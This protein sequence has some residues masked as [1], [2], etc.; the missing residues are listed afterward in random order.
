MKDKMNILFIWPDEP[1]LPVSLFKHFVYLGETAGLM[2]QKGHYVEVLDLSVQKI[3]KPDFINKLKKQDVICIPIEIY[4]AKS[5]TSLVDFIH[6]LN[7][8]IPIIAYGSAVT[9]N[10]ELF[11]PYFDFVIA[12]GFWGEILKSYFDNDYTNLQI[13]NK[14]IKLKQFP[15]DIE[16]STP[17]LE[18][19]PL[20]EYDGISNNQVEINTQYGCLRNCSFCM[21]KSFFP[22]KV[23]FQRP[24]ES[25]YKFIKECNYIKYYLDATTFSEDKDW[26]LEI[27]KAIKATGKDIRWKTVSRI[28][29]INDEVAKAMSSAGCHTISLGIETLN[30]DIQK[31]IRKIILPERIKESF[32]ILQKHN[33]QPRALLI[34]GLPGQTAEDIKATLEFTQKNDIPARWKEYNDLSIVKTFTKIDDF[35]C[36]ERGRYF[37]HSIPGLS[38][39][40]YLEILHTH[41]RHQQ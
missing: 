20:K 31:N 10:A 18:K 34:L 7:V 30:R 24:P 12:S 2:V 1:F 13:L 22:G 8:N 35:S 41:G 23:M 16:W 39:E 32:L 21:E 5:A 37:F 15:T 29:C 38:K 6:R 40:E 36:F 33:I 27:C 25:L 14:E 28:D 19:L 9:L 26:C 17:L 3:S 4:N 11:K